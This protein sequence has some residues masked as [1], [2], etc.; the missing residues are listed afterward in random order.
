MSTELK[1]KTSKMKIRASE[2][3]SESNRLQY[4][5]SD[6]EKIYNNLKAAGSEYDEV[7]AIVN[8]VKD[9]VENIQALIKNLGETLIDIIDDYEKS[10]NKAADITGILGALGLLLSLIFGNNP[11][12]GSGLGSGNGAGSG[13]GSGNG[14]GAG[15]GSGTGSGSGSGSRTGT[16]S[17]SGA[18]S[19]S[20]SNSGNG[21]SSGNGKASGF[22]TD[23]LSLL[24]SLEV[25]N[26]VKKDANGNITA[27]K[28]EDIGD[29][30]YTVGFG[31]YIKHGDTATINYY[32]EK[33]GIDVT[34]TSAYIP[35]EVC[36]EIFNDEIGKYTGY[37]DS[38]V[39]RYGLN[40]TQSQYDAL[41]IMAY[42]RPAILSDGHAVGDLLKSGNMNQSDWRNAMIEEYKGLK[43]WDKY[44]NGW[45]NRIDDELECFFD[46]DYKRN[47]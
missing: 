47:H 37:V 4:E 7:A 10:E 35:I 22:S 33:Y 17:G 29:G 36:Q 40:L 5:V 25:G 43:N 34:D 27:I 15:S 26:A 9:N 38:A 23:G 2:Y 16:G 1:V 18:G 6:L 39:E 21:T 8:D 3:K 24:C 13:S 32:K 44:G 14:S 41:T 19:E 46:G 12:S 31:V 45:T 42:N 28:I 30:G 20:G 11:G